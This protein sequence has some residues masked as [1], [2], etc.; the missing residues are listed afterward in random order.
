MGKSISILYA[1]NQ[2]PETVGQLALRFRRVLKLLEA[3]PGEL[4]CCSEVEDISRTM[5]IGGFETLIIG[6]GATEKPDWSS[7]F[8]N[9]GCSFNARHLLVF[10]LHDSDWG[11]GFPIKHSRKKQRGPASCK[12]H[13][14]IFDLFVSGAFTGPQTPYGYR[15]IEN[16]N[17]VA[18]TTLI[19]DPEEA[20]VIRSIFDLYVNCHHSRP[21]I[22]TL[23]NAQ[24][25]MPPRNNA[26][27]TPFKV[28]ALLA[29]PIYSGA[30]RYKGYLRQDTF[31]PLIDPALF[32]A[33]QAMMIAEKRGRTRLMNIPF[34]SKANKSP[35]AEASLNAK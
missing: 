27:W 20:A 19:P 4:V 25:M 33:A 1:P 21:V 11:H 32:H 28:D 22:A 18:H 12:E 8:G 15:R 2:V 31:E 16:N 13:D 3:D 23:L 34:P 24:G 10:D 7:W 6:W 9:I 5:A 29:D 30:S 14:D 35:D 17:G 26:K